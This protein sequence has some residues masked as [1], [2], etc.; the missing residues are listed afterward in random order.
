[1]GF[2]LFSFNA[3][4]WSLFW[5]YVANIV[6]ALVLYKIR[7]GWLQP[8]GMQLSLIIIA[9][10]VLVIGLSYL[11]MIMYDIPVRKYLNDKRN[12]RLIT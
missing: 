1:M 8:G 7:R 6:Y 5:E 9:G 10:I 11:V 12:E 4:S 2:N 3:S